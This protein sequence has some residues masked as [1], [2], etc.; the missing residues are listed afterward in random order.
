VS[1]RVRGGA[2]R[3]GEGFGTL[4]LRHAS[5]RAGAGGG[6]LVDLIDDGVS[7]LCPSK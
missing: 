2:E 3:K 1:D 6:I 5:L 7:H 4:K